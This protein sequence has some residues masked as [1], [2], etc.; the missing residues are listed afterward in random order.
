MEKQERFARCIFN[1]F[2]S[3][4][5]EFQNITLGARTRFE[6]ADWHGMRVASI[7]RIDL[8]KAKITSVLSVVE[9]I[10]GEQLGDYAF[11][12]GTKAEYAELIRGHNNFEMAETFYNSVY[13]AV[14]KH[15]KIRDE[16][17][18]IFSPHGDMPHP[19]VSKV[20]KTYPLNN[21]LADLLSEL[22]EDYAFHMPYEDIQR[23][24]GRIIEV[25][26]S[27]L[28]PRFNLDHPNVEFQIL[29]HH[30][31]R[32]KGAYIVGRIVAGSAS[33]PL[34]FP[35]QQN[36][37]GEIYIDTVL[38]GAD[39]CSVLF[40]FTRS[41]FMVDASIPSQYVLFL[42]QLMPAKPISEIYSAMGYNKHG[43][44]YYYR[45]AHR[46][47][48]RTQ[49]QFMIAPGIKG[50]VMSVFTMPSYD[51]VFKII[52]D[53]FTPPK[54]MTHEQVREKYRLVKRSDRAGRMA[55]TQEFTNLAFARERFSDELME[56]LHEVAPSVI[57]EHGKALIIKHVYVE[58]RMTPLNL[59]LQD[60]TEEQVIA[61]M[62]EYGNAIKQLASANIF[63]GDML[64]KNFGVTRHGRVVFYDYDEI[65]PLVDCNFRKIPEPRNEAEEMA[66]QPWYT[67]GPND[68][69]PE[70]FRLFF[71]GNQR[72]R[73]VFDEMHSDIYESE[74]WQG[75]Q[76][77]IR[78]GYIE[79]FF[80]YRRKLRFPREAN[81]PQGMS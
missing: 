79:D 73:K 31:F 15:R 38:F 44:T 8:Y 51:F 2:E 41:Y 18:F 12:S 69:F 78:S 52:K 9:L 71:S 40:S 20:V 22:F 46:H 81:N 28:A 63:P 19:D 33:M 60:A 54:D 77:R 50:M 70:E 35:I 66:S 49:D 48:T 76:E 32:N 26:N 36:E 1:G 14:F 42:Q 61:V 43:K 55:D 3:Y 5:A 53:R 64:L 16:Y 57:E 47:M 27:Y 11:W 68:I 65:Q 67:V 62:D 4:F 30:F 58:R 37:S 7:E 23:D 10:A 13:C 29:E 34:V 25:I 45:C 75:L 80:P 24:I 72:A 21:N 59:Y 74:F 56:E 17:A 39:K 6:N